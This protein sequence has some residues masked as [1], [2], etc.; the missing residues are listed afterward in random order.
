M[1]RHN[2]NSLAIAI[3]IL[4]IAF[5]IAASAL[6]NFSRPEERLSN[7]NKELIRRFINHE[8]VKIDEISPRPYRIV[9]AVDIFDAPSGAKYYVHFMISDDAHMLVICL[10]SQLNYINHTVRRD[11]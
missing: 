11:D 2:Y 1:R 4:A 10:D 8:Y 3:G 9:K 7:E 5:T 6:Y